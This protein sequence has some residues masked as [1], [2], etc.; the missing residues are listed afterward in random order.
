M[1]AHNFKWLPNA[2]TLT[3]LGLAV[4]VCLSAANGRWALGFW[5]LLIAF[6]TDF[7]DGLAAK[8]LNAQTELGKQLDRYTDGTLAGA[9][10]LGLAVAGV[11]AWWVL[12]AAALISGFLAHERVFWPKKGQIHQLRPALS[13]SFMLIVWIGIW[14]AYASQAYGWSWLYVPITLLIFGIAGLLKRHRL[15]AWL[16]AQV[17]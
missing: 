1:T 10:L 3:R 13:V 9:G 2:L 11:T 14:W 5:L 17:A 15:R 12:P 16:G 6:T 7:L 8:K 4:P